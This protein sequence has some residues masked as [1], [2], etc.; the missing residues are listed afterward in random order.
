MS[1]PNSPTPPFS[2]YRPTPKARTVHHGTHAISLPD[3]Q[4]SYASS[5]L[6]VHSKG[7]QLV[8]VHRCTPLGKSASTPTSTATPVPLPLL[9]LAAGAHAVACQP[10]PT[11]IS[12][13]DI[14]KVDVPL[15]CVHNMPL[16]SL[17]GIARAPYRV[18]CPIGHLRGPLPALF[19]YVGGASESRA[20]P[21]PDIQNSVAP[22]CPF[23]FQCSSPRTTTV[24]L[25]SH[26]RTCFASV[27][28]LYKPL[29]HW[30]SLR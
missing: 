6:R 13:D 8:P 24:S 5:P 2:L 17:H 18:T 29:Y 28:H 11:P 23:T 22:R 27:P 14:V 4:D 9:R 19:P 12:P 26:L 16:E 20:I 3:I 25:K 21:A 10:P 1:A 30:F 15:P 7:S